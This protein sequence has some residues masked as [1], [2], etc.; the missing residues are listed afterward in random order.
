LGDHNYFLRIEVN[1]TRDGIVLTQEKY[2]TDMLI[3]VGMSNCKGT[4]TPLAIKRILRYLKQSIKLGLK[5]YKSNSVLVGG[6]SDADWA[7]HIDDRRSTRGFAIFLGC[8]LVSWSA[9]KQPTVTL[10]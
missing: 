8:N 2:V 6:F 10:K 9:R 4:T 5:I 7:G 3:Q 1:Q